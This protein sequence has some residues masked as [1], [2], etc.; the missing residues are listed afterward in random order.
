MTFIVE[1]WDLMIWPFFILCYGGLTW[2]Y[3]LAMKK[4][5]RRHDTEMK[6]ITDHYAERMKEIQIEYDE[7]TKRS[8]ERYKQACLKYELMRTIKG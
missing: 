5:E 7:A 8:T 1:N 4:I 6:R 2:W 3:S